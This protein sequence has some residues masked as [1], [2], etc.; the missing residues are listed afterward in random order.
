MEN[1]KS[2]ET[3]GRSNDE[4]MK[5]VQDIKNQMLNTGNK[6]LT[7]LIANNKNNSEQ[8]LQI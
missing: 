6:Y 8:N 1:L 3:K 2:I 4:I 5:D 7:S